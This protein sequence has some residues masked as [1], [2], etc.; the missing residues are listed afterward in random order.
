MSPVVSREVLNIPNASA[1]LPYDPVTDRV[2]LIEQFRA[3]T[4]RHAEAPWLLETAAGLM[5]AGRDAE[6]TARRE[7]VEE[8]GLE[9]GPHGAGRHL[10]RVA[11]CRDRAHHRLHR[12]GRYRQGRRRARPRRRDRGHQEPRGS[13]SPPPSTGRE[14]GS[15]PP[16]R[17]W[18][19]AGSR[20]HGAHCAT[21]GLRQ[22]GRAP[23]S[24][25]YRF[26]QKGAATMQQA[27]NLPAGQDR[28]PVGQTLDQGL[29]RS[30]RAALQ[31]G[32]RPADRL[33]RLRRHGPAALLRFP[34]KEAAIAYC[35]RENL[36]YQVYEPRQRLVRPRPTP[37]TSS[38]A[39]EHPFPDPPPPAIE[40]RQ[41]PIAQPDRVHLPSKQRS[42]V[43]VL[44]GR[45]IFSK[46]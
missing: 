23:S 1:V 29:D 11:R 36:A 38:T 14:G 12:R 20:M 39:P 25:A 32:S 18:R 17:S 4:M 34:T 43:R 40:P 8:T 21:A 26:K 30:S 13:T 15:S 45:A 3:G 37:R 42:Q 44:Q 33:D 31:K 7:I 24:R 41:A 35:E 2:V 9:A 10:Y 28:G 6:T 46:A 22:Q 19:C 27:R 5:E 16:T